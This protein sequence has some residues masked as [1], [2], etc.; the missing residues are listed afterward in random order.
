MSAKFHLN[1][2]SFYG[3][4]FGETIKCIHA[5]REGGCGTTKFCKTCGGA[6]AI[7]TAINNI[8][9][10]RECRIQ[11]DDDVINVL[12]LRV[13][14]TPLEIEEEKFTILVI[15]DIS[16]EKRRRAMERIFFHDVINSV[17]IVR[18]MADLLQLGPA[19]EHAKYTKML[20]L[21]ADMLIREIMA[22]RDMVTAEN[23]ELI[24]NIDL[25]NSLK[26]L[27]K[28]KSFYTN[29]PKAHQRHIHIDSS[30]DEI[31]FSSDK[32]L[33]L[34]VVGNMLKNA[35]EAITPDQSVTLGCCQK[36]ARV[37]FWVHNPGV[38]PEDVKLQVFQRSF[39]T[40]ADDR[41]LGTYSMKL[42]SERYLQGQVSF[43]STQENGT[44]FTASYPLTLNS[45]KEIK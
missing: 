21:S 42:L 27:D 17:G 24:V 13:R 22:Q 14:T 23:H 8:P 9:D 39:S 12:D 18:G 7:Q 37:E 3:Q 6:Q 15:T 41:G 2:K 19:E 25:I 26:I 43:T 16:H 4:R 1:G 28:V 45:N 31:G 38:M 34:R 20:Y 29:H 32:T 40:K 5:L 10:V 36:S 30:S 11:R 44:V 35:L 33:L